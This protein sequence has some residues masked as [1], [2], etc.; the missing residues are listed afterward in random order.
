MREKTQNKC[1]VGYSSVYP[2]GRELGF[3][4]SRCLEVKVNSGRVLIIGLR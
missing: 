4:S 1:L 2:K 3:F